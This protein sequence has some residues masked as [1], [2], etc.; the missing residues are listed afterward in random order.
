MI[1]INS[2]DYTFDNA[3]GTIQGA[4]RELFGPDVQFEKYSAF[5]DSAS[6]RICVEIFWRLRGFPVRRIFRY[7]PFSII[8]EQSFTLAV[9]RLLHAVLERENAELAGVA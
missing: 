8:H 4:L 9:L 1:T 3:D 6:N 5:P 2:L 7:D